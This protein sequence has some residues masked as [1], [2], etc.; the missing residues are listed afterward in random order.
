MRFSEKND[1]I[2]NLYSNSN[3]ITGRNGRMREMKQS[4]KKGNIT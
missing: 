3:F 1:S 4:H 2:G